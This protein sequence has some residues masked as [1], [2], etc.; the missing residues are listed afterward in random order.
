MVVAAFLGLAGQAEAAYPGQ[1][2]KVV[3][4]HKADQFASK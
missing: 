1:N 2:G 3:Y 4:E